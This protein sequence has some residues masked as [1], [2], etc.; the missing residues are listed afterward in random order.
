MIGVAGALG[1]LGVGCGDSVAKGIVDALV[2]RDGLDVGADAVG[3]APETLADAPETLADAPDTLADAP[4]TLADAAD[5][6]ADAADTEVHVAMCG[7]GNP[8]ADEQCDDGDQ[9]PYD[10]CRACALEPALI[11]TSLVL[12]PDVG[13]DLDDADH[14]GDA[15]TGVDNRLGS[16]D[17]VRFALNGI[18]K[19]LVDAGDLLQ[20]AVLGDVQSLTSDDAVE[21]SIFAGS[22]PGCGGVSPPPWLDAEGPPYSLWRAPGAFAAC[23]PASSVGEADDAQNGIYAEATAHSPAAPWLRAWAD[24]IELP[25]GP[26]GVLAIARSRLEG[27]LVVDQGVLRGLDD[28]RLGGVLPASAL[29]HIDTSALTPLCPT[30]LQAVLGF[31]GHID[32]D[33]EGNG[34]LDFIQWVT[35]AGIPCLTAPVTI[36][37]C[38]DDGDC[39][40]RIAGAD[41][42][43]D[44]RIGDGFS[45]AFEVEAHAVHVIGPEP[46][47]ACAP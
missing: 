14:D 17:T 23:V 10:G 7:D 5:T 26:L 32:Q 15:T 30:A 41:C 37:G 11:L 13:W 3:D 27:H 16:S 39:A 4:D 31:A 12:S 38:C 46:V 21:V 40:N 35:T 9:C 28:G 45:A 34:K 33:T 8:E 43:D 6:L 25:A 19:N 29:A 2:D 47:D 18:L 22:D 36:T 24:R 42:V 20:I 1:L 44:P